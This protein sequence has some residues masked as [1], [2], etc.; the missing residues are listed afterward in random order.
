MEENV[1]DGQ[2]VTIPQKEYAALLES[3]ADN[4]MLKDMIKAAAVLSFDGTRLIIDQ[5][6]AETLI[7]Y[8]LK[9]GY[10]ATIAALKDE[11][12]K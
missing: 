11:R 4:A 7:K 3:K 1:F 10:G 6:T 5:G 8:V 9:D 2:Y 12:N